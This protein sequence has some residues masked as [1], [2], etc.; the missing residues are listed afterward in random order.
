MAQGF[1][2]SLS[3]PF[4]ATVEGLYISDNYAYWQG[5]I[6]VESNH[7]LEL[8]RPFTY[9]KSLY[10]SRV[11]VPR[12]AP[13]LQEL[14]GERVAGVLPALKTLFLEDLDLSETVQE[15]IGS[16]VSG[17]QFSCLPVAISPWEKK[18]MH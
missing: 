12:V 8:L 3:Q 1:T 4:S 17:R 10:L 7:W 6:R 16:F 15:A 11:S 14:V 2:S 18:W 9:V 13:P 5:D